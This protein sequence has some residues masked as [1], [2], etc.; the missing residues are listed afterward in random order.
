MNKNLEK[1]TYFLNNPITFF[2]KPQK[3]IKKLHQ[4]LTPNKTPPRYHTETGGTQSLH[5]HPSCFSQPSVSSPRLS[6]FSVA[7]HIVVLLARTP[8]FGGCGATRVGIRSSSAKA[9]RSLSAYDGKP[10]CW[11]GASASETACNSLNAS[12]SPPTRQ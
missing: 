3:E 11:V 4:R 2:L 6:R 8:V 1:A 12:Y 10:M 9:E 5:C 7:A